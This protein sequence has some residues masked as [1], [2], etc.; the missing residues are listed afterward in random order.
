[1]IGAILAGGENSRIPVLKGFI[2]INGSTIIH[3]N[4]S[5]LKRFFST[6]VLSTNSP[7]LYFSCGIPMIGDVL[8][9]RG[10]A[11]G[12]LSVFAGTGAD[13]L[14]VTGCDMPF[15]KDEVVSILMDRYSSL[16]GACDAVIP[17]HKNKPEPLLGIYSRSVAS[18]FEKRLRK[19]PQGLSEM[20]TQLNVSYI[21]ED[22]L[23]SADPEGR[24]FMNINT[25]EDLEKIRGGKRC[26][27]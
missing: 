20:L 14:L 13:A 17:M 22:V 2:E 4:I 9:Q 27:V 1:M 5:L 7:E 21:K 11:T 3:T 25:L 15:I 24:S 19:G 8:L 26:L 16:K 10:P 23:R 18:F 6:V 12:I